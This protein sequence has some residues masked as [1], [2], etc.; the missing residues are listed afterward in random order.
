MVSAQD[1][2]F[3]LKQK[4]T[5]F[6]PDGNILLLP[7]YPQAWNLIPNWSTFLFGRSVSKICQLI[8]SISN[9]KHNVHYFVAT[10]SDFYTYINIYF[11]FQSI[12]QQSSFASNSFAL[13]SLCAAL[14][15]GPVLQIQVTVAS[16]VCTIQFG[17]THTHT[18]SYI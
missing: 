17:S 6:I 10:H 15:A 11:H 1:F 7:V 16:N 9:K 12:I 18:I 14:F 2:G 13:F 5:D 8:C 4:V 3:E